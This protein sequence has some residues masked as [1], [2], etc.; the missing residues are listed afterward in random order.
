MYMPIILTYT[1]IHKHTDT[2]IQ[3]LSRVQIE[4][5]NI[6]EKFKNCFPSGPCSSVMVNHIHCHA[7]SSDTILPS[8]IKYPINNIS[9]LKFYAL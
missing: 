8:A 1:Y 5:C 9:I 7:Y 2:Y 4:D 6:G 3:T